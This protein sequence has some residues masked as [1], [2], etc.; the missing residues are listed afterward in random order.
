MW[1]KK[2]QRKNSNPTNFD[3]LFKK[4]P[5]G[6]EEHIQSKKVFDR[7][8]Y[9]SQWGKK[10]LKDFTHGDIRRM[11]SK[12]SYGT[13]KHLIAC[14]NYVWAHMVKSGYLGD[15]PPKN[16]TID[17]NINKERI[18]DNPKTINKKVIYSKEESKI[19]WQHLVREDVRA[20]FPFGAECL[21]LMLLSGLREQEAIRI[22]KIDVQKKENI[23]VIKVSKL[24]S[25]QSI[26]ITPSIR[27]VLNMIDEIA[28]R[29]GYQWVNFVPWLF[30]TPNFRTKDFEVYKDTDHGKN[31]INSAATAFKHTRRCWNYVKAEIL[32][33]YP[34]FKGSPKNFRKNYASAT[35]KITKNSSDTIRLTRHTQASTLEKFYIGEDQEYN[36][37]IANKVDSEFFDFAKLA[38]V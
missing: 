9:D 21:A 26:I 24:G 7:S 31:Y 23:I 30:C 15:S 4:Y 28:K 32:K 13:Q 2:G 38:A 37:E 19:I 6:I 35:Q 10:L 22:R 5:P 34:D 27:L 11:L 17:Y 14:I 18:K 29:P 20:K 8:I 12:Y 3:E 33:I 36:A 16:P 1:G 25:A